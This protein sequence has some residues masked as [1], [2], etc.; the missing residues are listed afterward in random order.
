[1]IYTKKPKKNPPP[2][3]IQE[4]EGKT[5]IVMLGKHTSTTSE[6]IFVGLRHEDAFLGSPSSSVSQAPPKTPQTR[7]LAQDTAEPNIFSKYMEIKKRN[8]MLKAT[9]YTQLWKKTTTSQH[10]LLSTCDTENGKMQI[11]F[12]EAK[13]PTLRTLVDY[14]KSVF[15]F[16]A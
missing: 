4:E 13:V 3:F 8:E 10:R 7:D 12:L 6:D 14:K 15:S 11:A 5:T 1:M 2:V 16:D 9:T